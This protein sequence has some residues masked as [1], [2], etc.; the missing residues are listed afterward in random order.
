MTGTWVVVREIKGWKGRPGREQMKNRKRKANRIP[1][2][3]SL[4]AK[5]FMLLN[6]AISAR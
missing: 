5:M 6:N 1:Y 4:K 2:I 3:L